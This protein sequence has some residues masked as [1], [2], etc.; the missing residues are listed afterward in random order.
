VR[1]D[2]KIEFSGDK[3]K[4]HSDAQN[5]EDSAATGEIDHDACGEKA[6]RDNRKPEKNCH[7]DERYREIAVREQT[8]YEPTMARNR[9]PAKEP[10]CNQRNLPR[11]RL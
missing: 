1:P 5:A 4:R 2:R 3:E 6:W 7:R 10:P 8:R 11:L 9:Y